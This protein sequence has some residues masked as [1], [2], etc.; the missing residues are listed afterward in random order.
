MTDSWSLFL[1]VRTWGVFKFTLHFGGEFYR[2]DLKIANFYALYPGNDRK[3]MENAPAYCAM[4]YFLRSDIP[5]IQLR[6]K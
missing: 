1:Q 5:Y 6:S 4:S 2:N 3:T